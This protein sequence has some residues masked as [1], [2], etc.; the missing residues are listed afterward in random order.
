MATVHARGRR[1]EQTHLPLRR[2]DGAQSGQ[3]RGHAAFDALAPGHHTIEVHGSSQS[4]LGLDGVER[5][6]PSSRSVAGGDRQRHLPRIDPSATSGSGKH[7]SIQPTAATAGPRTAAG[8]RTG[9]LGL[10]T[11]T[12]G[13]VERANIIYRFDGGAPF[14]LDQRRG[15]CRVRCLAP[16]HHTIEAREQRPWGW[17]E[18]S[19]PYSSRWPLAGTADHLRPLQLP[20][21]RAN[22]SIRHDCRSVSGRGRGRPPYKGEPWTYGSPGSRTG[23]KAV[24]HRWT[25]YLLG[26]YPPARAAIR[27]A[28]SRTGSGEGFEWTPGRRGTVSRSRRPPR[29]SLRLTGSWNAQWPPGIRDGPRNRGRPGRVERHMA[30]QPSLHLEIADL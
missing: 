22:G 5:A 11:G 13:G 26:G 29:R 19:A 30:S 6:L 25:S 10:A 3:R 20:V 9:A 2:R 8:L 1:T 24:E 12:R 4:R 14:T 21:G 27:A 7:G 15:P 17:T 16:G 23:T 18:W 28:G